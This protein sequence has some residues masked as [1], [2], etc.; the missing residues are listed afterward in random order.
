MKWWDPFQDSGLLSCRLTALMQSHPHSQHC[1]ERVIIRGSSKE[2]SKESGQYFSSPFCTLEFIKTVLLEGLT[3]VP[4][5]VSEKSELRRVLEILVL[6]NLE[7]SP[8]EGNGYSSLP[9]NPMNRGVWWF[10]VHGVTKSWIQWRYWEW[11]WNWSNSPDPNLVLPAS[12]FRS[13]TYPCIPRPPGPDDL[14]PTWFASPANLLIFP[15]S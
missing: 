15:A 10:T 11:A 8:G 9:G 7:D 4:S 12:C 5:W 6:I 13:L 1:Q 3:Q 14:D 2:F